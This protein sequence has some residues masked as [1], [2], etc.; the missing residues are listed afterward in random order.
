MQ[1]KQPLQQAL[2]GGHRPEFY[3][4]QNN[5][6]IREDQQSI[7]TSTQSLID[8]CNC[9]PKPSSTILWSVEIRTSFISFS[10]LE[11]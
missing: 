5:V 11:I 9:P 6:S 4:M 3:Q 2:H 8:N 1:A 7:R 10:I